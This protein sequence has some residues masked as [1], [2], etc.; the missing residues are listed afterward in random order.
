MKQFFIVFFNDAPIPMP[1][2]RLLITNLLIYGVGGMIAPFIG[3]ISNPDSIQTN[4]ALATLYEYGGF[5]SNQEFITAF[6][7]MSIAM[8]FISNAV[9]A[10]TMWLQFKLNP[11][12]LDPVQ[13]Q[14]FS[15]MPWVMMV[16][17][18]PFAAGLVLAVLSACKPPATGSEAFVESERTGGMLLLAIASMFLGVDLRSWITSSNTNP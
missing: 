14:I 9:S 5:Q 4:R 7:F 17:L 18:A 1:A 6:A 11:Q 12:Q 8:I 16:I 2:E 15:W 10:L 13:Q 3:I